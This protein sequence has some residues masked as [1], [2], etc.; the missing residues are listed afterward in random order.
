[1]FYETSA[2]ATDYLYTQLEYRQLGIAVQ[3]R[4]NQ[5]VYR[6]TYIG[7]KWPYGNASSVCKQPKKGLAYIACGCGCCGA[8]EKRQCFYQSK[9]DDLQQIV[10]TDKNAAKDPNCAM[11]GCSFGIKYV[12]CD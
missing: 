6:V 8:P 10:Q 2:D 9:G 1:M 12:Y 4:S 5:E 3:F 7:D 11:V